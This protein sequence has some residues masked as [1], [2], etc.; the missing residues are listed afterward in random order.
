M[1]RGLNQYRQSKLLEIFL[2]STAISGGKTE[3]TIRKIIRLIRKGENC[4]LAQPTV[5]LGK[6]TH[7]V[8]SLFAPDIHV[9][10]INGETYPSRSVYQ[11]SEH[12][13][14]PPDHPHLIITTWESFV[15]LPRFFNSEKFH[16]KI[17]E[18]LIRP[19]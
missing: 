11:S 15:R 2:S 18:V 17:D 19:Q 14:R 8:I 16:L 12:L 10:L 1:L 5:N 9:V 13:R 6:Q 7:G 4:I 3:A